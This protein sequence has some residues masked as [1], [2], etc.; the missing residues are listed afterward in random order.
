M[1]LI[2]PALSP[3]KLLVRHNQIIQNHINITRVLKIK[4]HLLTTILEIQV[5]LPKVRDLLV[6]KPPFSLLLLLPFKVIKEI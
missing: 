2:N 6:M 1:V 4:A 5:S 3:H